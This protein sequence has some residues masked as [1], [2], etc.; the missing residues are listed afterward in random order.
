MVRALR[1]KG[2]SMANAMQEPTNKKA[3]QLS[4]AIELPAPM[5]A[6]PQAQRQD[7]FWAIGDEQVHLRPLIFNAE[8]H[9]MTLTFRAPGL[10]KQSSLAKEFL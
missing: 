4:A 6:S 8:K 2:Y 5:I 1:I 9:S 10:T 7:P 3:R